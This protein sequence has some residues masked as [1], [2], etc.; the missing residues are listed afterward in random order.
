MKVFI[1]SNEPNTTYLKGG[2]NFKPLVIDAYL[3][4]LK[5]GDLEKTQKRLRTKVKSGTITNKKGKT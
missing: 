3:Y 1:P 4:H 2:F 5:D